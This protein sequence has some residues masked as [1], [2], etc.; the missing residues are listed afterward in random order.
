MAVTRCRGP[1]ISSTVR[2]T[3]LCERL[4]SIF[5]S[6]PRGDSIQKVLLVPLASMECIFPSDSIIPVNIGANFGKL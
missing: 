6:G 2:Q 4:W 3:P 1:L 5:S